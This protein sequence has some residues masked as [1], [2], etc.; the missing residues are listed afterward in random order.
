M[1]LNKQAG[2]L[3][4]TSP[5]DEQATP[6]DLIAYITEHQITGIICEN[7]LVAIE[8]MRILKLNNYN[9]PED[10]SIIGFDNI[11]AAQLVDPP[12]T[13]I[14]QD[15][16]RIGALAGKTLISWLRT[17]QMPQDVN[18]P[19]RLINRQSTKEKIEK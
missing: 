3:F 12:L 18:V 1:W 4:H 14:A 19:V 5:D 8:A 11:Q 13:T 7:D 10:I 15:F 17:G 2:F 9:V 16:T 6:N